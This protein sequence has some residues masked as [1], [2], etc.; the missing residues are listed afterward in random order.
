M[1]HRIASS[2]PRQNDT[3]VVVDEGYEP[4]LIAAAG[5]AVRLV[6]WLETYRDR[7]DRWLIDRGALLFRGF[8]VDSPAHFR[9]VAA[10]CSREL[11]TYSER[12]SPRTLVEE[13]VYTSTDYASDQSIFPHNEHSY[14]KRFPGRICF[15]CLVPAASGGETPIVDCRRVLRRIPAE[16]QARFHDR[17]GWLYVRNFGEGIGLPWRTVYQTESRA[18]V[19]QYCRANGIAFEWKSEDRLRTTQVRPVTMRHPATGEEIWFNHATFFNVGTLP[20]AFRS[21]LLQLFAVED[22]PNNTYYGDGTPLEPETLRILQE[23]YLTEQVVFP[24]Q[25]G[26][27]LLLDNIRTAHARHPYSGARQVLVSMADPVERP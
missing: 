4:L 18:D 2:A 26:D 25:R 15:G 22:L 9:A 14:A 3:V 21:T 24:W 19:E 12:S 17:Q 27:V 20:E 1:A 5:A 7:V 16:I 11:L 23:A 10:A 6:D 13:H 8:G